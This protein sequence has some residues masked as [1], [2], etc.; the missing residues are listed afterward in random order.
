MIQMITKTLS[1]VL[2]E[3][4]HPPFISQTSKDEYT[5]QM[6][7]NIVQIHS[8]NPELRFYPSSDPARGVS[9]INN[10]ENY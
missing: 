6:V 7:I 5:F 10:A 9:E 4:L 2:L 1:Y 8:A 3:A